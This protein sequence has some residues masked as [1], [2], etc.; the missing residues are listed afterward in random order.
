MVATVTVAGPG[1]GRKMNPPL[2][3]GRVKGTADIGLIITVIVKPSAQL[4][5]MM[6]NPVK[7]AIFFVF[8][9]DYLSIKFIKSFSAFL[10]MKHR[11]LRI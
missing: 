5:V 8:M 6:I 4:I 10:R 7:T 9:T 2:A 1:A 3:D 11:L